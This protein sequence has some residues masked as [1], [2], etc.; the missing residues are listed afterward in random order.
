ME[1]IVLPILFICLLIAVIK[2]VDKY[3]WKTI[4]FIMIL[5]SIFVFYLGKTTEEAGESYPYTEI[6]LVNDKGNVYEIIKMKDG[7]EVERIVIDENKKEV[8]Q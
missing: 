3:G 4:I 1:I 2:I 8:L 6:H 5:S 7:K